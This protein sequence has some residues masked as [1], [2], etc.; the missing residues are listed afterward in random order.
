MVQGDNSQLFACVSACIILLRPA[1][2]RGAAER[3]R[4]VIHRPKINIA[5]PELMNHV[6]DEAL[7]HGT[8]YKTQKEIYNEYRSSIRGRV[9]LAA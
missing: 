9:R 8:V 3:T 6:S 5:Q 2:W 7:G 4:T 1:A